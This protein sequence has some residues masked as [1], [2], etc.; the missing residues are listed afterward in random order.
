MSPVAEPFAMDVESQSS[1]GAKTKAQLVA[2]APIKDE[3]V[4]GDPGPF[5]LL[6]FGMTTCMLMFITTEWTTKGFLPTVFC[7]AMFY[8]GLGQFVAGVLELIKGNTFG[9]TAFASYGAFWMG[10]F[11]LEYLTWTNKALYAGVQSGKSLWCGLWA[12]LTFGFFIVTC[13][14]NGCLMTI[15]STL[16]ITFA[17]LSGGVWDPRCE[18]AAGY[19]GFFCGSSAIYAAFV[20]LYKI[21]LG[22]S[23]PGVR[24][25]AFL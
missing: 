9:G 7:Y 8:G 17:L 15:F 20:F 11:L 16:V 19:F 2:M 12:V 10:W 3:W 22:I 18:Q 21:E 23:L 14:K 5:G 4:R 6:C 24:P 25:V 13:R 1:D